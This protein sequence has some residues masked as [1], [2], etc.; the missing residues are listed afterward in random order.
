VSFNRNDIR[1][2]LR[3]KVSEETKSK[4]LKEEKERES[5][6]REFSKSRSG[7]KVAQAGSRIRSAAGV[8]S[9]VAGDQ[10]GKMRETLYSISEFVEKLGGALSN[11]GG[12]QS[13]QEGESA[14]D[15]L[16][17]VSELKSLMKA[18]K[19]LEK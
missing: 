2:F 6:L 3:G 9:E 16:P 18:I 13:L 8:I 14:S 11:V 7:K 12:G 10:T 19:S 17:T 15:S 1:Y 5:E 4:L